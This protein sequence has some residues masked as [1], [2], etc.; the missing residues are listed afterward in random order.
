MA[1]AAAKPEGSGGEQVTVADSGKNRQEQHEA[2]W[3]QNVPATAAKSGDAPPGN[4]VTEV[5]VLRE[6]DGMHEWEDGSIYDGSW[7]VLFRS[8]AFECVGTS[9]TGM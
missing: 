5:E 4:G 6:G 7:K 1:D 3:A 2:E 8:P 9:P